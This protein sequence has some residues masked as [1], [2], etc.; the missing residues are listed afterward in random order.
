MLLVT[1]ESR[2]EPAWA[3]NVRARA[4]L[5]LG[6]VLSSG[7]TLRNLLHLPPS[8]HKVRHSRSPG[9]DQVKLAGWPIVMVF[10]VHLDGRS[11]H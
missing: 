10:S 5:L 11:D 6:M 1:A 8:P 7:A 4:V 9:T 2:R 3:E